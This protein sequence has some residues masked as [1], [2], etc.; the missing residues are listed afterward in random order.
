VSKTE[1]TGRIVDM[2]TL[3]NRNRF[4]GRAHIRNTFFGEYRVME[5][6]LRSQEQKFGMIKCTFRTGFWPAGLNRGI[7]VS[8]HSV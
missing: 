2:R 5:Y 8:K 7:T 3:Y 1:A 4:V 6:V